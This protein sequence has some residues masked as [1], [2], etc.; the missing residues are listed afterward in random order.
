MLLSWIA[1]K[2]RVGETRLCG[3]GYSVLSD[4]VRESKKKLG[5][6]SHC[7]GR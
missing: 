6:M 1:V 5:N 4:Y 3:S 7:L 2:T